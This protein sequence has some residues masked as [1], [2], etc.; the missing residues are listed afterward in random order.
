[1]PAKGKGGKE[2]M[3]ELEAPHIVEAVSPECLAGPLEQVVMAVISEGSS[4]YW[5]RI[6]RPPMEGEEVVEFNGVIKPNPIPRKMRKFS[7]KDLHRDENKQK[8]FDM[9][10]GYDWAGLKSSLENLNV[11]NKT[12]ANF[13]ANVIPADSIEYEQLKS[14]IRDYKETKVKIDP[15][16]EL[17]SSKMNR[18]TQM[19]NGKLHLRQLR[20]PLNFREWNQQ[21]V[22]TTRVPYDVS[23]AVST[24]CFD[25]CCG[26]LS[27]QQDNRTNVEKLRGD[28]SGLFC[29][30][31]VALQLLRA[32]WRKG[33]QMSD[34]YVPADFAEDPDH[35]LRAD[36]ADGVSFGPMVKLYLSAE[37]LKRDEE[38]EQEQAGDVLVNNEWL[39]NNPTDICWESNP[40]RDELDGACNE[41]TPLTS[42]SQCD[43][44]YK[45]NDPA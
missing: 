30:G 26:C 15:K 10:Q 41:N 20:T 7:E 3:I 14:K 6:N 1:V 33:S 43:P 19:V 44:H 4:V 42:Y 22:D 13:P 5:R 24:K 36:L 25:V 17:I 23:P 38:I 32:G 18:G 40:H 34:L 16:D 11:A 45:L 28:T 2:L 35:M 9:P 37:D 8:S 39:V 27:T 21:C 29:S 12:V 31:L